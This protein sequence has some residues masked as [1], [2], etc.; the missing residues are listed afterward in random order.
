VRHNWLSTQDERK[1]TRPELRNQLFD[2]RARVITD[3]RHAREPLF[4]RQMNNQ[5]IKP[6][7]PFCFENF[8]DCNWIEGIGSQTVDGFCRQRETLAFAQQVNRAP[9]SEP[10]AATT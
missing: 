5:R 3:R 9:C 4:V 1:R 2:K 7:S 8:C 6:R 10:L